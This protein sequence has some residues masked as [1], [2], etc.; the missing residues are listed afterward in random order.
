[1]VPEAGVR[2]LLR[3][4]DPQEPDVEDARRP[5]LPVP[6]RRWRARR[7][8]SRRC[9]DADRA[10]GRC[11]RG[12]PRLAALAGALAASARWS[13]DLGRPRR[14]LQHAARAQ[15]DL[16]AVG[17]LVDPR[18]VRRARPRLAAASELTGDRPGLGRAAGLG[19]AALGPAMATYTAVLLADTA[20]PAWHEAHRELPFVFA[21]SALAAGGGIGL[22][23]GGDVRPARRVA[24]AG[25]AR[26]ADRHRRA[27]TPCRVRP[28][29]LHQ[30]ARR[31]PADAGARRDR[32]RGGRRRGRWPG[33]RAAWSAALPR[34]RGPAQRRARPPPGSGSSR[35]AW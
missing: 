8:C 23:A 27:R 11:E 24:V 14:F 6:R 2:V 19:A 10:A 30:R 26:R 35:R 29:R 32:D 16:A 15:A 22:A 12:R 1:M 9:A 33:A 34:G 20:V 18:A 7:R 3:Q 13:H 25:A 28:H 17:G 31:A 5:A 21:G 4:A